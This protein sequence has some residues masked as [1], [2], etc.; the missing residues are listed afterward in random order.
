MHTLEITEQ[1]GHLPTKCITLTLLGKL[2]TNTEIEQASKML[3][4]A[5]KLAQKSKNECLTSFCAGYL[6]ELNDDKEGEED[7]ERVKVKCG[8]KFEDRIQK[9]LVMEAEIRKEI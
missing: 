3:H 1:L 8:K 6:A 5:Y 9:C 4:S 7:Y 2:F